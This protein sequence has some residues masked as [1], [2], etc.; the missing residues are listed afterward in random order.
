GAVRA[1]PGTAVHRDARGARDGDRDRAFQRATRGARH[2]VPQGR[3]TFMKLR[4]LLRGGGLVM[5]RTRLRG[6]AIGLLAVGLM[7]LLAAC[8]SSDNGGGNTSTGGSAGASTTA[9]P[10][11]VG[12]AL[13]LPCGS[14]DPWCNQGYNAAQK[15]ASEGV[16]DLKVT[17]GAP[18]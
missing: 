10:K 14:S 17:T 8:G 12:M 4:Q 18:Q 16:V 15:L 6:P 2:S 1:L 3:R 9:A 11:K 5:R 7:V 13:V